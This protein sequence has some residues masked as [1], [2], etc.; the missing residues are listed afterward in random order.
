MTLDPSLGLCSS[1]ICGPSPY[2]LV[3]GTSRGFISV[4]YSIVSI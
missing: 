3:T 2:S 4:W 1:L